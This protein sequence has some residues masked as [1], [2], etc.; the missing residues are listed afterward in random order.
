MSFLTSDPYS[1]VFCVAW[2]VSLLE[3]Y[4]VY[5]FLKDKHS[6]RNSIQTFSM[7]KTYRQVILSLLTSPSKSYRYHRHILQT[8]NSRNKNVLIICINVNKMNMLAYF[9]C[10]SQAMTRNPH[11]LLP[12]SNQWSIRVMRVQFP[13][14]RNCN[15]NKYGISPGVAILRESFFANIYAKQIFR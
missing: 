9:I 12:S 13:S 5:H 1:H 11:V 3:F 14:V 2:Q 8:N 10:F 6:F 15:D 4:R 7:V